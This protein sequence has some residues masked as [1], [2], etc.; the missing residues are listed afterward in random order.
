MN[1]R[2]STSQS[3]SIIINSNCVWDEASIEYIVNYNH[4]LNQLLGNRVIDK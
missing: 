3:G 4:T 2:I 1:V